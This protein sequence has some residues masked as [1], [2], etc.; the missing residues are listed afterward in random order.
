MTRKFVYISVRYFNINDKFT[1]YEILE[2]VA[3]L[4]VPLLM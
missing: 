4:L 1:A 3:S 2:I